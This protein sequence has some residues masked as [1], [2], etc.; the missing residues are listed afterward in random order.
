MVMRRS[1][2]SAAQQAF[3]LHARFPDAKGAL[4]AGRLVWTGLL[5]PT[6]LS[7]SYRVEISYGPGREP[8]VRVLESLATREG[9]SL[10]HV[11]ADGTL[12]LH[13]PGEWS[14]GMYIAD[15]TVPWTAEWLAN[16][17]IW[18]AT[19]DWHGGGEWPP[20]RRGAG[21]PVLDAEV[22]QPPAD[23]A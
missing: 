15:T 16:Y 18:L 9:K 8:R 19:G 6:P 5:Q 12:C 21:D 17:E 20:R 3:A 14:N 4:K 22:K 7:R 1:G 11:F 23:A 13:E 10:P 2:L